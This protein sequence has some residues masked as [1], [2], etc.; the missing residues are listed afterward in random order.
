[1]TARIV[2]ETEFRDRLMIAILARDDLDRIGSVTGP[3]RSGAI[4][5]VYVSHILGVPFL[6]YGANVPF[7]LGSLL[8]ADT[9]R[10]TGKTIR[11]AL[12]RY[13]GFINVEPLV[14]FEEPPRVT[15][16]YEAPK[17]Q[18]YRHETQCLPAESPIDLRYILSQR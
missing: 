13:D 6:P 8:I 16:W 12:R 9:A 10:Q 7:Q 3:G 18:R 5:A 4:A 1:M 14:V 11:K 2:S 15:F 17:P